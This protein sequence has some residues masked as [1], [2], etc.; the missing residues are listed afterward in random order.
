GANG[1]A[2]WPALELIVDP[3]VQA[4]ANDPKNKGGVQKAGNLS[5]G[6]AVPP[7]FLAHATDLAILRGVYMGT[8]SHDVG[9]RYFLT[10]KFP[11]GLEANGSSMSTA[12][13]AAEGQ[14]ALVPN[15]AISMEAYND[16]Y[17]AYATPIAVNT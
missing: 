1:T 7:S 16:R 8:L 6:P 10:G 12:V 2:I 11:R 14:A 13:A 9:R 4:V 3:R 17:P 15:L 5:F